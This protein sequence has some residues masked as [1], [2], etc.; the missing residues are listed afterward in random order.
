MAGV[1]LSV[2]YYNEHDVNENLHIGKLYNTIDKVK[3]M[4]VDIDNAKYF[5][6]IPDIAYINLMKRYLMEDPSA[7][8]DN[9]WK[10][11]KRNGKHI[12]SCCKEYDF[13]YNLFPVHNF[14]DNTLEYYCCDCL[15]QAN[16][17]FWCDECGEPFKSNKLNPEYFDKKVICETC[18]EHNHEVIT[19]E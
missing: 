2:G 15:S 5:E 13:D 12:C 18:K 4:L 14:N 1:N 16:D 11:C 10:D 3:K 7:A 8:S 9:F 19:N 6:Y 17:I